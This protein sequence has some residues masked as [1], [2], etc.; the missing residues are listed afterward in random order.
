MIILFT[1]SLFGFSK[2]AEC[3]LDSK[4]S[5]SV[6][7]TLDEFENSSLFLLLGL[8]STLVQ[9]PGHDRAF[10]NAFQNGGGKRKRTLY[11]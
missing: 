8:P 1:V 9:K 2:R 7:N 11:N 10:Q 6:N 3:C 4:S 5:G